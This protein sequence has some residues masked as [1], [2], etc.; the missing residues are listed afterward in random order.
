MLGT[1]PL[2]IPALSTLS[3]QRSHLG[4]PDGVEKKCKAL[5]MLQKWYAVHYRLRPTRSRPDTLHLYG[6]RDLPHCKASGRGR[7]THTQTSEPRAGFRMGQSTYRTDGVAGSSAADDKLAPSVLLHS[8]HASFLTVQRLQC[9]PGEPL[10]PLVVT[11]GVVAPVAGPGTL[12]M[13]PG[14]PPGPGG[15]SG[16]L[17]PAQRE[18]APAG[19]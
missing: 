6:R 15:G 11:L 16:G 4:Q 13:A 9:A 10:A 7:T 17:I 5:R 1:D 19:G 12:G 2:H 3:D 18:S 8:H 14:G